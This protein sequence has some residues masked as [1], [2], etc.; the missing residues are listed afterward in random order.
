LQ[1]IDSESIYTLLFVLYT[2]LFML[3]T[4]K[5]SNVA[6]QPTDAAECSAAKRRGIGSA[7]F[8]WL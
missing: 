6:N 2:S 3:L 4:C 8:A 1:N 5:N 7:V